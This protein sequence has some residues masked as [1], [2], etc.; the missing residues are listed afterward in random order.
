MNRNGQKFADIGYSYPVPR[1]RREMRRRAGG[2][3]V[4]GSEGGR[5]EG[6][7][8]LE[9]GGVGGKGGRKTFFFS[10]SSFSHLQQ[11]HLVDFTPLARNWIRVSN[12]DESLTASALFPAFV[13]HACVTV[14]SRPKAFFLQLSLPVIYSPAVHS[15]TTLDISVCL[16]VHRS[17]RFLIDF[18]VFFFFTSSRNPGCPGR[19][20]SGHCRFKVVSVSGQC[21]VNVGSLSFQSRVAVGSMSGHCRFK[22]VSLSGQCR[23]TVVVPQST[24]LSSRR[25]PSSSAPKPINKPPC[26]RK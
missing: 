24:V 15:Q 12:L 10:H 4:G 13:S 21:R 18:D 17:G 14:F 11:P 22:V 3:G 8:R 26:T 25:K 1:A 16:F 6:V 7:Q 5:G 23:V 20:Q 9:M 2:G 19:G